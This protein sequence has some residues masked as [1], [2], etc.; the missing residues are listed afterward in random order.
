MYFIKSSNKS[1]M[2]LEQ[3]ELQLSQ[4]VVN[5]ASLCLLQLTDCLIQKW[6]S[7]RCKNISYKLLMHEMF[8]LQSQ[9]IV[10]DTYTNQ[11]VWSIGMHGQ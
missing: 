6:T 9:S 10:M 5:P 7:V 1:E 4:N 3:H 8:D 2:V 11:S